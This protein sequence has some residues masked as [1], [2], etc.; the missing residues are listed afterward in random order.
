MDLKNVKFFIGPVSKNIVDTVIKYCNNTNKQIGLIPSRRQID[1]NGG[2]VGWNTRE[3]TN[4]IRTK[5]NNIILERDH[6]GIGQGAIFDTGAISQSTDAINKFDIIHIDPW[7]IYPKY[8]DGLFETIQNIK[9]INSINPN[10]FFEVGTEEAIRK[11][12]VEEFDSFLND[13]KK[14]L[15]ILFNKVKYGVIQSGTRLIET[16]NIGN[17][18]P[19]KL[20]EMINICNNHNILSKEHNGDYL[21]LDNIKYKFDLGLSA[22]NIAPEFGV[23]ETDILLEHMTIEQREIFFDICHKSKKW[24]NW[25]NDDFKPLENKNELMRICGHYQFNDARFKKLNLNIND[26]IKEKLYN[27]IKI[28]N[29]L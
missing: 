17:F 29:E 25:V 7:K 23:F 18:D 5:S 11:F 6:S 15:G 22:I 2:Y 9:Y 19:L 24:I 14:E 21:S 27:K 8:N 16:K 12:E 1:Y 13:L 26:I 10:C 28:M 3:F 4:Y 20:K